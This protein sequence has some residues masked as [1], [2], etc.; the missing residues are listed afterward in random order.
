M[1][2]QPGHPSQ[3]WT[4]FWN[5]CYASDMPL[6]WRHIQRSQVT[7]TKLNRWSQVSLSPKSV[8][9]SPSATV[10]TQ[11]YCWVLPADGRLLSTLRALSCLIFIIP[12]SRY[13]RS[14]PLTQEESKVQR[15]GATL[16]NVYSKESQ[17]LN[18]GLLGSQIHSN[19]HWLC[20]TGEQDAP[21]RLRMVIADADPRYPLQR[22]RT[23]C[24]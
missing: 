6:S 15:R 5:R 21:G 20:Q 22:R 11:L 12:W 2:N 24:T 14:P 19:I 8:L 17:D 1:P 7:C 18:P 23:Q 16:T 4:T 13:S 3:G 9:L 10:H